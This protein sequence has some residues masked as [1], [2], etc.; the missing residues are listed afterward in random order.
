MTGI[1]VST[2]QLSIPKSVFA[3]GMIVDSGTAFTQ[4][5]QIAFKKLKYKNKKKE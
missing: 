1:T 2:K 3:N 4:L 5:P